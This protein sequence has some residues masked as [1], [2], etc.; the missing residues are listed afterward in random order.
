[1]FAAVGNGTTD[2]NWARAYRRAKALVAQFTLEEK[3]NVTRGWKGPCVG[4]TGTV[5]RLGVPS[6]CLSDAPDGVRGQ[7]FVSAFP[8]GLHLAAT[9]DKK[10]MYK[11]GYALGSEYYG[12]GVN[13]VLGPSAGPMGRIV[14]GGRN[15][16]GLSSDPFLAATAMGAITRGIQDAGVIATPKHFLFNEQEWRRRNTEHDSDIGAP[17]ARGEAISA[18]VD[19]RT[20]HELY[21]YPFMN[22]LK[23]GAGSVMC[24][25]QRANHSYSCQNSKLMNGILK[26]ELGFE[27]FVVSDWLGQM[28]GVASANAGLDLVMPDEG[29]WGDSLVEAVQN[30]TVTEDRIDDMATRILATWYRLKQEDEYPAVAIH[31]YTD[32]VYPINVQDDH[33]ET[34][35]HIGAAGTV[36]VKNTNG[37]LPLKNP[38]MLSIY[39]Y[40]ATVHANPWQ[41]PNRY[42]GG[43][44]VNFGWNTFNGTLITGGGSGISTPPYIISPFQAIQER[45][46]K[47]K[48]TLRWDFYSEN[49][50][51]PY[52]ASEACLVFINAYAS[53]S[54]DR[55]SLTD[56]FSDN[57]V[58]NVAAN[59]SNTIVTIHHAGKCGEPILV[60]LLMLTLFKAYVLWMPGLTTRTSPPLYTPVSQD[61]S[62]ETAW[63]TFS[64]AMSILL[65][66]F[67]SLLLA[68]RKITATFSIRA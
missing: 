62:L 4:N 26:T 25:Y 46:R 23:E 35:R 65:A 49:P 24:S 12:K 39:G 68:K 41:N 34:I 11:Y 40:D 6:I 5:P 15:W 1:M 32:K 29:Y 57:L 20:L 18:N 45:I 22:A 28:S 31:S 27:G 61:K 55:V 67:L 58:N 53:E 44:E 14:R 63:W 3:A 10:L 8:A 16:E 48:G 43:Y 54:F 52:A 37:T 13:V 21:A 47:V 19:D 33:A 51:P 42:G 60:Y 50:I 2:G 64:T 9:F 30:G 36:V 38:K 7:E 56:E 59:C 17:A 66:S